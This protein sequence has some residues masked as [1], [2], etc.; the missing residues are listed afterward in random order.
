MAKLIVGVIGMGV[1]GKTHAN[2]YKQSKEVELR[3]IYDANEKIN[4]ELTE[5]YGTQYVKDYIEM[6]EDEELDAVSIC[7]SD[8]SH[9]KVA[10]DA[11]NYK[12]HILIEKPLA[13]NYEDS[14]KIVSA[15]NEAGI[16]MLVGHSLRWDP[17]YIIAKDKVSSGK[18]GEVI[19]LYARRFNSHE[20]GVR[21][22]GR[23]NVAM[24]LGV[25]DIDA[26]EWITGDKIVEVS[27]FQVKK[28]LKEYGVGDAISINLKFKSGT[29]G[30]LDLAWSLPK[31]HVEID[32][33]LD[34]IG[35]E[36]VLNI[37]IFN[38]GINVYEEEKVV[39]PDITY[40]VDTHG[41]QSGVM[42]EEIQSF[43]DGVLYNRP[44][45]ISIEE[46]AR[47]VKIVEKIMDSI[48]N[49]TVEKI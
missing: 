1:M 6:L 33:K 37:D 23:T 16:K 41:R 17:R 27:A 47:S 24:F 10:L 40:G 12:K 26:I 36:G 32:A 30:S 35:S 5:E 25:H 15:V 38:Q 13:D 46:A 3:Y 42:T 43:I 2:I 11:C 45:P 29:V 20:N 14:K 21:I 9:L 28:R 39:Y 7:T 49:G 19:H 48:E 44:F 22:Q 4:K 8:N 31:N 18:I 34:L